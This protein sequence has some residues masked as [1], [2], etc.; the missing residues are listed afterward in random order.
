MASRVATAPYLLAGVAVAVPWNTVLSVVP[1]LNV[2]T[3][4]ASSPPFAASRSGMDEGGAAAGLASL[5]Y[6]ASSFAATS[7]LVSLGR[8]GDEAGTTFVVSNAA[9]L[10]AL[11]CLALAGARGAGVEAAYVACGAVLGTTAAAYQN[12]LYTRMAVEPDNAAA[13]QAFALGFSAAATL[14]TGLAAASCGGDA[15][16]GAKVS[17]ALGFV[18]FVAVGAALRA[19]AGARA[20]DARDGAARCPPWFGPC[21][22]SSGAGTRPGADEIERPLL[23]VATRAMEAEAGPGAMEAEARPG[24]AA[25]ASRGDGGD[26]WSALLAVFLVM[27][28]SLLVIPV[29][30]SAIQPA[31]SSSPAPCSYTAV[32][33]TLFNAGDMAGRALSHRIAHWSPRSVLALALLRTAA[34][35]PFFVLAYDDGGALADQPPRRVGW[36]PRTDPVARALA[37]LHGLLN[38]LSFTAGAWLAPAQAADDRDRPRL[39]R[40]VGF[41]TALGLSVGSALGAVVAHVAA[42]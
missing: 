8:A 4:A 39:G 35:F 29:V 17:L 21:R 22:S 18:A 34:L 42:P 40:L 24:A 26:P 37:A 30:F 38:G 32:L 20:A 7:A 15:F 2:A 5:A 1:Y 9:V 14:T 12:A 10:G 33:L 25:A 36:I 28:G 16:R 19:F 6:Q 3:A 11:W 13:M 31:S 23:G 27:A 41:A